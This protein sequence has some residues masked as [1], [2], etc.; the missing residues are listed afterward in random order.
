MSVGI[1]SSTTQADAALT[2][3]L[4]SDQELGR[5]AFLRL[6]TTQLQNQDPLD[7]VQNEDFVAQLAQFSSLEQL[8]LINEN[9][10][11][12]E[13]TQATTD[14]QRAVDSNTAVAMIGRQVQVPSETIAYPGGTVQIGYNLQDQAENVQIL[15]VD[16]SGNTVNTVADGSPQP[17]NGTVEW[18]GKDDAGNQV[19]SGTYGIFPSASFEGVPV[20]VTAGLSGRVTG[21][22][23]ENGNPILITDQGEAP[24]S[25]VSSV[26]E[27]S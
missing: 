9:L 19:P 16:P 11:T 12:D 3:A 14:V 1:A 25:A 4:N 27:G 15:I 22:R 13:N 18:D 23:F 21:I 6:L 17:G 10:E 2:Q 24:L 7:P 5:D 20:S 8:T 26:Y